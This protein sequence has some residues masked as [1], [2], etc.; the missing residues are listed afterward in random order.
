MGIRVLVSVGFRSGNEYSYVVV[1][2]GFVGCVLVRRF[3]EDID[4][5]VLL[6][7]VGFKDTYVGSKRFL[8]K[9]YMF[10]VLVV[11]LCDDRYNWYYY[12][13]S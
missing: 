3:T 4:K 9:I 1:G 12:T 8:W 6:L 7:E 2:V 11:N 13:E 5:R 10:V